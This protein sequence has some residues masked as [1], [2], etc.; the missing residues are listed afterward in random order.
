MLCLCGYQ[1]WGFFIKIVPWDPFAVN[2]PLEEG[3]LGF[4]V[5]WESYLHYHGMLSCLVINV[6]LVL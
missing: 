1:V 3:K 4:K 6:K 2:S 5:G